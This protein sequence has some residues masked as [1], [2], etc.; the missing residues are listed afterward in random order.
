MPDLIDPHVRVRASFLESVDE[1]LAEGR[2][3]HNTM[4]GDW[5]ELFRQ[6]GK[7]D[8]VNAADIKRVANE[9]FVASNRTVGVIES[10]SATKG[11]AK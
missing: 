8:K 5:R 11:A 3:G 6:V 2:G 9:T 7:I 10:A 1:F 4:L